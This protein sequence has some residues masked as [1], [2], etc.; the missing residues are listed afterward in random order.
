MKSAERSDYEIIGRLM[1]EHLA[2]ESSDLN[3]S[4]GTDPVQTFFTLRIGNRSTVTVTVPPSTLS[5]SHVANCIARSI[6]T[7][8]RG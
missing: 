5:V 3:I 8:K 6:D 7:L 2:H 4:H 1:C